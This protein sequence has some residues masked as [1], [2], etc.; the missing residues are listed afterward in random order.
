[1]KSILSIFT[2]LLLTAFT[3][4]GSLM[5]QKQ[6]KAGA[7][8]WG[9]KAGL[10]MA[11]ATG[12]DAEFQDEESGTSLSPE[13]RM[14]FIGGL[15]MTYY[16]SEQFAFQPE[17]LYSQKGMNYNFSMDVMGVTANYDIAAKYDYIDI[18]LLAKVI[19]PIQ[20]FGNVNLHLGPSAGI[21]LLSE[22]DLKMEVSGL[23]NETTDTTVVNEEAKDFVVNLVF[24]AGLGFDTDFGTISLE[25]RYTMGMMGSDNKAEGETEEPKVKLNAI[26]ILV[27]I[28]FK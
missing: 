15:F 1:M 2:I 12:E 9:I 4:N 20:N 13:T 23:V 10:N 27:S 5:A 14:G 18:P 8:E 19:F 17:M 16:F 22:A 6:V 24:G 28:A 25:G 7:I 11:N 3:I 26:S 21:K